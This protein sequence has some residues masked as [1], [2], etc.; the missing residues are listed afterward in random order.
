MFLT[1]EFTFDMVLDTS[2][3]GLSFFE[4]ALLFLTQLI[5][6]HIFAIRYVGMT[7]FFKHGIGSN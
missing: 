5:G 1:K 4:R 7:P 3:P 6:S 2:T